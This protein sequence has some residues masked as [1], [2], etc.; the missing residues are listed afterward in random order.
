MKTRKL[1]N[2]LVPASGHGMAR[3]MAFMKSL[4]AAALILA[5][6]LAVSRAQT[7]LTILVNFDGTNGIQ[8]ECDL[9]Q[10]LDGN[11]YG[12]TYEGGNLTLNS[13]VGYGSVFKVTLDGQLTP[14]GAFS[15]TNG[16]YPVGGV[17]QANDGNFYG[18]TLQGGTNGSS[19]GTL[20]QVATNGNL[21][22]MVYF[23][24]TNGGDPYCQLVLGS[25]GLLYGTTASGLPGT[26]AGTI[27]AYSTNSGLQTLAALNPLTEGET[28]WAGLLWGTNGLLYGT[29]T[30]GGSGGYGSVF[31]ITT[32]GA[33]NPVAEFQ[34]PNPHPANPYGGL[35][36]G[37][38]GLLYGMTTQGGSNYVNGTVY[39]I[40]SG[41]PVIVVH[42]NGTNG[43]GPMGRLCL[44]SNNY[45][46]GMTEQ[47]GPLQDGNIFKISPDGTLTTLVNFAV[48]N[49][50]SPVAGLIQASDG[51]L[52]GVT[53]LGGKFNKGILFR[54][55]GDF[56]VPGPAIHFSLNQNNIIL[57]WTNN[58]ADYTLQFTTGLGTTNW[59]A[60]LPQPTLVGDVY[61][62]TNIMNGNA[63]FYR[64]IQSTQQIQ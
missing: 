29:T 50:F 63:G 13:G 45:L 2:F 3:G 56:S 27:F 11:L 39:K 44:A 4:F 42:F 6:Q 16:A 32:N 8:P 62:Y 20:Y 48:T 17:V 25:N 53:R 46:Y 47:G 61:Y 58:P 59:S 1:Y 54:L 5:L 31:S 38:D 10:G 23:N 64:L 26:N 36:Y 22:P 7:N 60:A 18:T 35:V 14:L 37:S 19:Y 43:S 34:L 40:T 57:F 21:T 28:P 30:T 41:G 24:D 33:I 49:G 52:Y 12:T 9:Y 55:S 15:V 51:N